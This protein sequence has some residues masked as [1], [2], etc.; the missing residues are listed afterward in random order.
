MDKGNGYYHSDDN[1]K[2][3][4]FKKELQNDILPLLNNVKYSSEHIK[5]M[6]YKIFNHGG[7][8]D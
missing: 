5:P 3:I 1:F 7:Y 2:T 8:L 4:E 6:G